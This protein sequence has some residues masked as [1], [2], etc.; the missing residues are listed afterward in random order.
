MNRLYMNLQET[1]VRETLEN[2]SEELRTEA[3][4]LCY[5]PDNDISIQLTNICDVP[6]IQVIHGDGMNAMEIYTECIIPENADE[7]FVKMTNK[8]FGDFIE[9]KQSYQEY[10]EELQ[11]RQNEVKA[12]SITEKFVTKLKQLRLNEEA[13]ENVRQLLLAI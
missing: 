10:L 5:S 11:I 12:L 4:V 9:E 6:Q 7:T 13:K 1:T 8:F 3:V 2:F